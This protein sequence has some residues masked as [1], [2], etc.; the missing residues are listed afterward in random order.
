MNGTVGPK[1]TLLEISVALANR[2][3]CQCGLLAQ[4]PQCERPHRVNKHDDVQGQIVSRPDEEENLQC[5]C[6]SYGDSRRQP[7]REQ[8]AKSARKNIAH[9][10][11]DAVTVVI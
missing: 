5:K 6:S 1:R 7:R 9:R 11:C 3:L 2:A 10:I 4:L 8:K